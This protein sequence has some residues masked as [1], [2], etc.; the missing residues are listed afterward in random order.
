MSSSSLE[1]TTRLVL[2]LWHSLRKLLDPKVDPNAAIC[3]LE[4]WKLL[5][6]HYLKGLPE[7]DR[8]T[9][10]LKKSMKPLQA[11]EAE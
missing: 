9:Q 11:G 10:L 2:I 1:S 4:Q 8:I 5:G 7:I 3:S 6:H